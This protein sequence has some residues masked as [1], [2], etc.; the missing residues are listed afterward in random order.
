MYKDEKMRGQAMSKMTQ[1]IREYNSNISKIDKNLAQID[2]AMKG[3]TGASFEKVKAQRAK[4]VIKKQNL[5]KELKDMQSRY[6][7]LKE[8][9]PEIV[10]K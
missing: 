6:N 2:L 10:V 7:Y 3:L 9:E 4:I 8:P 5:E 1:D